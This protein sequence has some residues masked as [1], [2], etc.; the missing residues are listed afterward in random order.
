MNDVIGRGFSSTVYRGHEDESREEV[1]IKVVEQRALQEAVQSMVLTNEI[2]TLL[3]LHHENILKLHK[4]FHSSN[5]T[6]IVTEFCNQGDM[7]SYLRQHG[8]MK[9]D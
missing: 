3:R 4:V 5:N 9:E 1:A 8:M 2:E 7:G 6:Y